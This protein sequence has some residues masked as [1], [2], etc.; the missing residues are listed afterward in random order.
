MN[1]TQCGSPA[2]RWRRL[3]FFHDRIKRERAKIAA[4][5]TA[6]RRFDLP[7]LE[8]ANSVQVSLMKVIQM[9]GS[10][11]L[12]HRTAGLM[13]YALQTASI[14]LRHANFEA[15][16]ATDVVIDRDDIN[17]TSLGGPQWFEEDFEDE[18][19]EQEAENGTENEI[20]EADDKAPVAAAP[21][22]SAAAKKEPAALNHFTAE[23]ARRS[24]QGTT[25]N[26]LPETAGGNGAVKPG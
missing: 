15:R 13:L 16:F 9:L 10:G 20:D 17:R 14:N 24:V 12:D 11:R 21:A 8:D 22:Q 6:Q 23:D 25:R 19:E 5:M 7:L 3:C 26:W 18:S 4:D 2:L 1:G